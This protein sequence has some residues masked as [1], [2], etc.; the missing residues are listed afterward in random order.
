MKKTLVFLMVLGSLIQTIA[1][2]KLQRGLWRGTFSIFAGNESPFNLEIT[3]KDVFLL[4]A[5]ERFELKNYQVKGDSIFIPIDIFDAV[6]KAKIVTNSSITGVLKK[7][8]STTPDVPFK[9][10]A[11]KKYRFFEEPT[12]A[13]VSLQGN[14]DFLIGTSGNKTVGVFNQTGSKLTGTI[15]STTGDYRF[16]E[17]SV[18]GNEFFL[19]AFSGSSPSLI[20]GSINGDEL[21]AEIIGL[22]GSQTVKGTRNAKAALPNA[23]TL[24]NLKE[25]AEFNFS[26]PDAFTGKIVTLKDEK[27]KGK[28]VIVTILGSWCPNCLDEALF[29]SPWYKANKARGIEI[30]GLSYERKNDPVFAKTRLEALKTRFDINYDILF[31]GLADKNNVAESLPALS[32]F[33]SFP[34][35][36][37]IDKNGKVRK[38][39]TGYSGPATGKYYEEFVK[40]FN[41]EVNNLLN[42]DNSA[43]L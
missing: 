13:N 26:F 42:P 40:E 43:K 38:I 1:Q 22:R 12:E 28:A 17:G 21:I 5:S 14:W 27:Y 41:E 36:I 7:Y 4:N 3:D 8:N 32:N 30:I 35:T 24:T 31:C 19:S 23:Y 20:K 34:T 25:G 11:G 15:L 6:L 37:Y 18:K 2:T 39:H 10:V 9:A 16:F 33:L 29:L